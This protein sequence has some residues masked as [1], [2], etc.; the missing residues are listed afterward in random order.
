MTFS[1]KKLELQAIIDACEKRS[2]SD[3]VDILKENGD[4]VDWLISG[5]STH[6]AKGISND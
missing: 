3:E 4:N 5:L 6:S 2:Y 1:I